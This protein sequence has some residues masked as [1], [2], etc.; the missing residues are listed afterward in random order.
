MESLV[1]QNNLENF[2]KGKKVF[3]TGHT[4]FKG[5]WLFTWLHQLGAEIKGYALAPENNESIYNIIA[6]NVLY[7]FSLPQIKNYQP[8]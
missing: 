7:D 4:G 5:A 3:L 1:N 6:P 2:Y 8:L